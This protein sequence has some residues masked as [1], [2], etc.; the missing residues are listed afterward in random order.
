MDI[1]NTNHKL[2]LSVVPTI[3]QTWSIIKICHERPPFGW[4]MVFKDAEEELKDISSILEEQE[5]AFGSYY[6][7]KSNI[8]RAF[9]LTPLENVRVVIVG[10][11]PYHQ[12]NSQTGLPRA[13]GMSFSV[14]RDDDIPSSL[15]NI[16][17]EL[18]NTTDFKYPNHGD[19]ISWT[20]QGV[21]LLNMCLTVRPNQAGSH[22][23]IWMGFIVKVLNALAEEKPNTIYVLWGSYA[24]KLIKYI[25]D[26]SVILTS[27]H[28]SGLSAHRGFFGCN[29]FKQINDI[30]LSRNETPIDWNLN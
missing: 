22:G 12:V 17:K 3:D 6:P 26:R 5:K 4:K 21:L 11:D 24:Q 1:K 13:Q 19:L 23:D 8:F 18:K 7:L 25:G 16:F 9:E 30:L 20:R 14:S 10:Q 15:K 27:A 28:P 2:K 29:H